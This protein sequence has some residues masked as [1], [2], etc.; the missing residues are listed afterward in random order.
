MSI[1]RSSYFSA[2]A[3]NYFYFP[4]P[5]HS[6]YINKEVLARYF[7]VGGVRIEDDLLITSKGYENLT[8]APKGE[9]MLEIIKGQISRSTPISRQQRTDNMDGSLRR[10]PGIP[11][12]AMDPFLKPIIRASTEPVKASRPVLE[13]NSG[14]QNHWLF[15]ESRSPPPSTDK[16]DKR[17]NSKIE[18]H[19]V[20]ASKSQLSLCGSVSPNFEH[21][22]MGWQNEAKQ[23][24]YSPYLGIGMKLKTKA[25]CP[26]CVVL[27]ETIE[28]LRKTLSRSTE[29]SP[30]ASPKLD[31]G[32]FS[33]PPVKA[34]ASSDRKAP[35]MRQVPSL[36][37]INSTNDTQG[38]GYGRGIHAEAC[39]NSHGVRS[40]S[41]EHDLSRT[42]RR[43]ASVYETVHQVPE[44]AP[45]RT[46]HRIPESI[47]PGFQHGFGHVI[48]SQNNNSTAYMPQMRTQYRSATYDGY[49]NSH[50]QRPSADGDEL[51]A[52]KPYCSTEVPNQ[53]TILNRIEQ[54]Y[55][56]SATRRSISLS[57]GLASTSIPESGFDHRDLTGAIGER[58]RLRSIPCAE[59]RP[60]LPNLRN[61]STLDVDA[62]KDVTASSSQ[63]QSIVAPIASAQQ[64]QLRSR[65]SVGN[66]LCSGGVQSQPPLTART[67]SVLRSSTKTHSNPWINGVGTAEPASVYSQERP[68]RH[69][70]P[71]SQSAFRGSGNVYTM[72]RPGGEE[73]GGI[74]YSNR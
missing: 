28:R 33:S 46:N 6:K 22:T 73:L 35:E 2:Y 71:F 11:K 59:P 23:Q 55:R 1:N 49:P 36:V 20:A 53:E 60:S 5:I 42:S 56:D 25:R 61:Y 16:N 18:E 26:Q 39:G 9:A 7:P 69:N 63:R 48:H 44:L 19:S 30:K 13:E 65:R 70:D 24:T 45:L 40:L 38:N 41:Q 51:A 54:Y 68:Y 31:T 12:H 74:D 66:S 29:T 27:S 67:N 34:Q 57:S 10:A 47:Q 58:Q 15:R 64:H 32:N 62:R 50:S 17:G 21:M 72:N 52:A 43:P 8:T 3:L 4:S 14:F 37:S